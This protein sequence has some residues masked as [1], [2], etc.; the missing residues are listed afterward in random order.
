LITEWRLRNFKSVFRETAIRL[1]PLTL[2]TGTN[3]SGKST[4]I[5]SMLLAAQAIQSDDET[6]PLNGRLIQLGRLDEIPSHLADREEAIGKREPLIPQGL[7][8]NGN[9]DLG[10]LGFGFTRPDMPSIAL[11]PITAIDG[12]QEVQVLGAST[13]GR[14]VHIGFDCLGSSIDFS[15]DASDKHR[16]QTKPSVKSLAFWDLESDTSSDLSV[17]SREIS[18]PLAEID[19]D[20]DFMA[21]LRLSGYWIRQ[22]NE[23][24]KRDQDGDEVHRIR[25]RR[26]NPRQL[27]AGDWGAWQRDLSG[28]Q[29]RLQF[30]RRSNQVEFA[31]VAKAH[32][33]YN[34]PAPA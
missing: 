33:T 20:G 13:P 30:W 17:A 26:N 11:T 7:D 34:P 12:T 15:F 25:V 22:R 23:I 29:L 9:H 19:T 28:N 32:T 1:A 27:T 31:C 14:D 21:N 6:I 16:S 3:S 18:A 8:D 4:L 5:Q 24:A 2:L 10:A